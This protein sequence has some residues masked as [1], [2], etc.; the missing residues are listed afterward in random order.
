MARDERKEAEGRGERHRDSEATT[1][2]VNGAINAAAAVI[3]RP[4][5][6]HDVTS[7]GKWNS[8]SMTAMEEGNV[9]SNAPTIAIL[10]GGIGTQG[11]VFGK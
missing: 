7:A 8:N 9:I 1:D 6:F 10:R 4:P 2:C 11:S 5:E 3:R